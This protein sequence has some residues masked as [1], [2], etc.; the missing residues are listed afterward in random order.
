MK[1][2]YIDTA[3]AIDLIPPPTERPTQIRISCTG[4]DCNALNLVLAQV[5]KYRDLYASYIASLIVIMIVIQGIRYALA[6]GDAKKLS[7]IRSAIVQL[8]LAVIIIAAAGSI[9]VLIWVA[10]VAIASNF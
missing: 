9:M 7:E 10:A 6:R 2:S 8:V 1:I 4:T 5:G 3:Q